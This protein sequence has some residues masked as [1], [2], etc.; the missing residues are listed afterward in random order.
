MI[1]LNR[2]FIPCSGRPYLMK[3]VLQNF[4]LAAVC[5]I[6]CTVEMLPL[7]TLAVTVRNRTEYYSRK[8]WQYA[9]INNVGGWELLR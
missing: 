7:D 3:V 2:K 4:K 6:R 9:K 8:E 1:T 5:G